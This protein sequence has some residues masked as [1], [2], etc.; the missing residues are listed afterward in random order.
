VEIR[1][2]L[3]NVRKSTEGLDEQSFG[4][5]HRSWVEAFQQILQVNPQ[6]PSIHHGGNSRSKEQTPIFRSQMGKKAYGRGP[7][8]NGV[9]V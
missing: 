8:E 3:R 2:A 5:M 4:D 7:P 9:D 6:L 1:H